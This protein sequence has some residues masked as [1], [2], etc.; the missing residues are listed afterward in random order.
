MYIFKT[1]PFKH[2][3]DVLDD[4]WQRPYYGLFMEMGLG[5][6]KVAIDTIGRL[7]S[8]GEVDSVMI[9]APKGV[10]DNWVKQEIPNH[11]PD[12]FER[13][14]VRWQPSKSKAFQL[15]K[16]AKYKRI[17]TGSPVTKS[18]M[19]LYSQCAFLD[20]MSLDQASYFAFQN[21]YA[22]V[23]K[24]FMGARSFNEITGYRR[25]DELNEK[26]NKFSVRT[27]KE[28][29][30]DLPEKI[31]IKRSVPLT[32]EQTKL[33]AQMKK[34]ALAQLDGGQ[35]ATTASVLTQIM[36]LQQ[37][38]CGYLMSD[39]GELK[40][41][42]NNR[43]TELLAA[44]EEC[45]GKVIIWCNYTHDI[46]EIE[47]ALCSKYGGDSVATYY[48]ATKQEDRQ[49][50]VDKFQD[51]NSPLRFFVGQ[52]K[53]GGYGITL[54]AANTMIYYSNSY[55]LEIRLQS[56]DRAHRIG[57]KKAVTYIDLIVEDTIDEK[58][59]KSLREKI[60]LAGQVLGED[61]KRWLLN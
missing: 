51:I 42:D 29:C 16:Y 36:R 61:Q 4:S 14:V 32:A 28:D 27:L 54:T 47:K 20:T 6:S 52:P 10:Y 56:E 26:L 23:Q 5:K 12:E 13:F 15:S 39:E 57:Q 3:K 30:L 55:D 34:Y 9:V 37:I 31:Y 19:D 45:S 25:L 18:P 22:V 33:Y 2:Q 40:V 44:V 60:N 7:K 38:C 48:G 21:R 41:L 49:L 24:R 35:L 17:L 11:L 53:T 8:K 1:K 58:I 59:V 43:M 50:T 46:K